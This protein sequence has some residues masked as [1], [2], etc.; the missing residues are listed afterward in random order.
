MAVSPEQFDIGMDS[1]EEEFEEPEELR[2]LHAGRSPTERQRREHEEENHAVYREWCETC[3]ATKGLGSQHRKANRKEAA[4]KEKEG[5]RVFSDYFFMNTAADAAPMLAVKFSRS[6]RIAA[7]ALQRKGVTEY[8]TK[9]FARFVEQTGVKRYINH[10]DNEDSL[11]ALKSAAAKAVVGVEAIPRCAPVEDHRANGDIECAVRELKRQMR[12]IRLQLETRLGQALAGDDPILTWIPTFAGD[13]ISRYRKGPDGKTPLERETGRKWGRQALQFGEKIFIREA[14][15]RRV[16]RDWE[17][18]LTEVR[19][20]GHHARTGTVMGL[21]AEGVKVG[22]AV[23]R[24]PEAQ[25]W[26]LE[27][28]SNLKGLPWELKPKQREAPGQI[29]DDSPAVAIPRLEPAVPAAESKRKGFYVT[30]ADLD[31]YHRTPGCDGCFPKGDARRG[32][33]EECRKRIMEKV[34]EDDKDRIR[35]FEEKMIKEA[36][37]QQD[38]GAA[39]SAAAP[40]R[41]K[42]R[43]S[44]VPAGSTVACRA[45]GDAQEGGPRKR[46]KDQEESQVH[47]GSP[48]ASGSSGLGGS[49]EGIG[50]APAGSP[51]APPAVGVIPA[52]G[53]GAAPLRPRK[54]DAEVPIQELDPNIE[55][56]VEVEA[57]G[58]TAGPTSS[59]AGIVLPSD[60]PRSGT[61]DIEDAV[62]VPGEIRREGE[63]EEMKSVMSSLELKVE[64]AEVA[65]SQDKAGLIELATISVKD[66]FRRQEVDCTE[67]EA[68]CIA[69][70]QVELGAAHVLELFSPKRFTEM[71]PRLGLRPG[72]AVDLCEPKPYG[73]NQGEMWDLDKANDVK[74]LQEMVDFE[75]PTLLTGSPPCGPF[76]VLRR[77]SDYKRDPKVVADERAWGRR[78]LRTSIRFYRGQYDAGRYFLHEHPDGADSWQDPEMKA[79]QALPGVFTVKGPMCRWDMPITTRGETGVAYKMTRYV[80]NSPKLAAVLEG[81]CSNKTGGPF[82]VHTHLI[83]GIAW[84]AAKYPPKMVKAVLQALKEQMVADGTLSAIEL[85]VG[86]PIPSQP[87][88]EPWNDLEEVQQFLDDISG[89]FLPPEL[90]TKARQEEIDWC[91]SLPLYQKI[92]RSEMA[93]RGHKTV[94]TRWVDVN[95]G[96]KEEYKVRSRLVGKELK[97]K[98]KEALLAHEL[99]SAMPPWEMIKAL[100]SLLVTKGVSRSGAELELGIFDIS[101][102]HFMPKADRELYIDIPEEDRE[103]GDEGKVAL[104]L[105]NMYGFR[106]ASNGW[107]KDWQELLQAAGYEVGMANPA[108]FFNK[109]KDARGGVHGDDFYVLGD[110]ASV[111]H[112]GQV[113]ASKY[114]V[115]ESHRLGFGS[116][117]TRQATV[118]NR[119]VTLG[120]DPKRFV[121]VE[122]DLRHVE[123]ILKALNLAEA[124]AKAV[125]TPGLKSTDARVEQRKREP[126]VSKEETSLFRSC[127]MRASF[128]SQDRADLGEAVKSLAQ[129]M[130]RPTASSMEDLKRLGR[131]LKGRPSVAIRYDEQ[132]MPHEIRISVDSDHAGDRSTRK[133][134]TGMVQRLG[135]HTIKTSSNL[136]TSVGLN[137]SECEFYALVHGAAHGLGLQAFLRDIGID[138]PLIVESDSNAAKSFANRRGLGKQRHVETR[139]L[140]IQ[141]RIANRS[142]LIEKVL[143]TRNVSDILTKAVTRQLL[144]EHLRSMGFVDVT[145]SMLHKKT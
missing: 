114:S 71:A 135:S 82:H 116:H 139:Y 50:V 141:D 11:L 127:L 93:A 46:R 77:L 38:E 2:K 105:R 25:R 142:F 3:V 12:A 76:S 125:A 133:S 45:G 134:T 97:A 37:E 91:K 143:G 55:V 44:A 24:L 53:Q 120:E 62:A 83:G 122:P 36:L 123:L 101:R 121:Q 14:K 41:R 34:G 110:R 27:G 9:F 40:S 20:I 115:R 90:V 74:E 129:H 60:I 136:Q 51:V 70:M 23:K 118:L 48:V 130:A 52:A 86:G 128:L 72:F 31:K 22:S 112:I 26:T 107:Q 73:P 8:G 80:T 30:K 33:N 47:A 39:G 119:V 144:D 117:C 5:P 10:S 13:V 21:S 43:G 103:P 84:Q 59:T 67:A 108:L 29:Q 32:H 78:H 89:E 4:E 109:G 145:P 64:G 18:K 1:N 126:Q 131:Y 69:A 96:D 138:L 92:W 7:T 81:Q 58:S 17:V 42:A 140:W 19:Y 66:C 87:L 15:E 95:K 75:K 85:Q 63:D 61:M 137:V 49:S 98:T 35:D 111:D 6:K 57:A 65:M 99:F 113:L 28:W 124:G 104:L 79:L 132:D 100:L 106:T 16:K 56:V 68:R 102:A 88:I 94:P 54:R